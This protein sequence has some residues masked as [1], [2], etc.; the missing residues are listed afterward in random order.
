[1][2]LNTETISNPKCSV[3]L[4]I[5]L[6]KPMP[7]NGKLFITGN[8]P[9]LGNW[10][11]TGKQLMADS[12]GVY[13]IDLNSEIGNIIEC[14]ITRGSWKTQGISNPDEAPPENMVIKVMD[15]MSVNVNIVDWLDLRSIKSDPV[16]GKLLT[17]PKFPCKDLNYKRSVS[18]WL[19]DTYSKDRDKPSAVIYMHDGQNLFEPRRAFAG[20]DWKVDETISRLLKNGE[21][22]DC[23]VIGIPNSPDR[24]SELNLSDKLGIAYTN[25]IVNEVKPWVEKNFNVSNRPEDTMIM[26]SSMGGLISFQ[27]IHKFRDI[28]GLA[29]CVSSSFAYSMDIFDIVLK[30]PKL[31]DYAKI[32][33]DT[34]EYEPPIVEDYYNMMKLLKEKGYTE[35]KDLM[36]IFEEKATHCEARW[37]TRLHIPFKFLLGR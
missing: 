5:S 33:L 22:H 36:G 37:A 26:G 13:G 16:V 10:S 17:S 24:M 35:G 21:I 9:V 20:V 18:V 30:S 3:R 14:K 29:G 25:F 32:Y 15:D 8:M 23:I 6:A 34:G 19:P 12:S 11:P 28:F 7:K 1:M 27:M 31:P 4:N 2:Q